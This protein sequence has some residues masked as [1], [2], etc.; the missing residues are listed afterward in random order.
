MA[1]DIQVHVLGGQVTTV[2]SSKLLF[3]AS[4]N[5]ASTIFFCRGG[6]PSLMLEAWDHLGGWPSVLT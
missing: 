4:I 6:R 1:R 3:V 2:I 5:D